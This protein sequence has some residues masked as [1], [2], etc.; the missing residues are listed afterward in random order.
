MVRLPDFNQA[1]SHAIA[2]LQ[3]N[4]DPNLTY[5]DVWHT[6]N[7]VLPGAVRLAELTGLPDEEIQLLRVAAAFHDIGFIH[8][9]EDH[10]IIGARIVAQV[11]PQ[12]NFSNRQIERIMG[13][14]LATR[15]PQ[16][17]RNLLEEILAD[18]DLDVL[19]REDFFQR[20]QR[21]RQEMAYY[22]Q[23][24]TDREWLEFQ[25]SFLQEHTYFTDAAKRLRNETKRA[26]I[27]QVQLQL[28]QLPV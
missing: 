17:P 15:M 12:F 20:N 6:N 27:L 2:Q 9:N 28:A 25:A 26:H 19:G 10:E 5:H 7:D 1:V 11:L 21:L 8:K 4:L 18:A 16:S 3:S 13:M 22:G 23:P 24:M 14:I